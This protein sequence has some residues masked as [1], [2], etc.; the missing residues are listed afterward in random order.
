MLIGLLATFGGSMNNRCIFWMIAWTAA[1]ARAELAGRLP[2]SISTLILSFSYWAISVICEV[3][4]NSERGKEGRQLSGA[5]YLVESKIALIV[6][7]AA[8]CAA[9]MQRSG[10]GRLMFAV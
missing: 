6:C 10:D 1:A 9:Y 8:G 2:R 4:S 5:F 3:I 7:I